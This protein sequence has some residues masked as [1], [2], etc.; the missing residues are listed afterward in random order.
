MMYLPHPTETEDV[1]TPEEK[2]EKK[3]KREKKPQLFQVVICFE[4]SYLTFNS[5]HNATHSY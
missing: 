2:E 5:P 4:G 3:G 1:L